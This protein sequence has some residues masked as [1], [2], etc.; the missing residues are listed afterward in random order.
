MRSQTAIC[1][2][3]NSSQYWSIRRLTRQS[4]RGRC[5]SEVDMA[6][7]RARKG[8]DGANKRGAD[9]ARAPQKDCSRSFLLPGHQLLQALLFLAA[10]F[11][12]VFVGALRIAVRWSVRGLACILRLDRNERRVGKE[13]RSRW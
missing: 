13:C 3:L 6:I 12:L 1:P 5:V 7:W 8:L 9:M 11:F 4:Q 2:S 10:G